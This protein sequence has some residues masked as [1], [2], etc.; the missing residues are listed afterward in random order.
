MRI[1]YEAQRIE[2]NKNVIVREYD[3][4]QIQLAEK[5]NYAKI[6]S[7]ALDSWGMTPLQAEK[8]ISVD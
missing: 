2:K 1:N 8:I 4:L 3:Q 6:K 7:L 5:T